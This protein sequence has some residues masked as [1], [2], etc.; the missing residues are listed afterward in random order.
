M[1]G[2]LISAASGTS[3]S[4]RRKTIKGLSSSS[5]KPWFWSRILPPGTRYALALQWDFW[6]FSNRPLAEVQ[7]VP[8]EEARRA[9]SLDEKDATA[10]ATLAHMLMWN[11]EWEV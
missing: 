9:V 3:T 5:A 1:P 7:G 4:T 8:L 2:R 6:N 10:H 11:G